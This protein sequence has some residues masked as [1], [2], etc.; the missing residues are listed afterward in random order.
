MLNTS[1]SLYYC[2]NTD[3]DEP[4]GTASLPRVRQQA[5]IDIQLNL[6]IYLFPPKSTLDLL[7]ITCS[8]HELQSSN[9]RKR[10]RETRPSDIS[11][12]SLK[13]PRLSHLTTGH[14]APVSLWDS[15]SKIWLTRRALDELDRRNSQFVT[16]SRL[17]P[18]DRSSKRSFSRHPA[19][20]LRT[21]ARHGGPD[22]SDL[23]GVC[24]VGFPIMLGLT[25]LFL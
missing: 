5:T 13:K 19:P 21:S 6:Y 7:L 24:I 17:G 25:P 11:Q 15:L 8:M 4:C 18:P 1:Q 16:S 23:R 12:A 22:L 10:Q 2:K 3:V 14:K 9:P 20:D